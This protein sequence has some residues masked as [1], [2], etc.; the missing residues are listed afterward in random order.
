[1]KDN[2]VIQIEE[3]KRRREKDKKNRGE[4]LKDREGK[5]GKQ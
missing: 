4:T 1:M 2:K 5:K 3:G